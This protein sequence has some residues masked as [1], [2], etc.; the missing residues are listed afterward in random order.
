MKKRTL[1][2]ALLP[3]LAVHALATITLQPAQPLPGQ[4]IELKFQSTG[5][6]STQVVSWN[7]GDGTLLTTSNKTIRHTYKQAGTYTVKVQYKTL[8]GMIGNTL[9]DTRTVQVVERRRIIA[10]PA[11]PG[12]GQVVSLQA[13]HCFSDRL[14]WDFGDGQVTRT[15]HSCTHSYQNPGTYQIKV[16]EQSGDNPV[17]IQKTLSVVNNRSITFTPANPAPGQAVN[18]KAKKF[19]AGCVL[20]NFGDG[21]GN[22]RGQ[23][24]AAHTFST[25]GSF[26]VSARDNCGDSAPITRTLQVTENRQVVYSPQ[27]PACGQVVTFKA[28]RFNAGCVLWDFGDNSGQTR[29]QQSATHTFSSP[30]T[31]QISARDNC[32]DAPPITASIQI[33]QCRSIEVS[34]SPVRTG[35]AID[36]SA[37]NF[38]HPCVDWNFGDG[39]SPVQ[40]QALQAHIFQKPGTYRITATDDCGRPGAPGA[41]ITL[42]VLPG[43]SV[44]PSLR[45]S[46]VRIHFEN[47]KTHTRIPQGN[48][49]LQAVAELKTMGTGSLTL[50]WLVDG[51]LLNRRTV[52]VTISGQTLIHSGLTP[53]LPTQRPGRHKVTLRFLTPRQPVAVPTIEYTVRLAPAA[54]ES[55]PEVRMEPPAAEIRQGEIILD[56]PDTSQIEG[57]T[58][59]DLRP[60]SIHI[61]TGEQ[62]HSNPHVLT[63]ES[64]LSWELLGDPQAISFY[65]VEFY[66]SQ[67]EGSQRLLATRRVPGQQ[68]FLKSDFQLIHDLRDALPQGTASGTRPSPCDPTYHNTFNADVW[69]TVKGYQVVE[70]PWAPATPT[71]QPALNRTV[72]PQPF[73]AKSKLKF[74]KTADEGWPREVLV[75]ENLNT[76]QYEALNL[77]DGWT[78]IACPAAGKNPGG[79]NIS[80]LDRE[81]TITGFSIITGE[82]IEEVD[83]NNYPMERWELTG[84]IDTGYTPMAVQ[85]DIQWIGPESGMGPSRVGSVTFDNI[86]VDWGDGRVE[87]LQGTPDCTM[88]DFGKSNG[89]EGR[90]LLKGSFTLK[91]AYHL[92]RKP[93]VYTIRI[94]QLPGGWLTGVPPTSE[95]VDPENILLSELGS[96]SLVYTATATPQQSSPSMNSA[97]ISS[98]SSGL[99]SAIAQSIGDALNHGVLFYCQEVIITNRMDLC[100]SG[101]LNLVDIQVTGFPARAGA[102]LSPSHRRSSQLAKKNTQALHAPAP[103][104]QLTVQASPAATLTGPQIPTASTCD[105]LFTATAAIRYFGVGSVEVRWLVDNLEIG[106]ETFHGLSSPQRQ[107]L[108]NSADQGDCTQAIQGILT[109]ESPPLPV[110]E[111]GRRNLR[112]VAR[113]VASLSHHFSN[114]MLSRAILDFSPPASVMPW[115][116]QYLDHLPGGITLNSSPAFTISDGLTLGELVKF[117]NAHGGAAYLAMLQNPPLQVTVET[118]YRVQQARP[119]SICRLMFP[120]KKGDFLITNVAGRLRKTAQGYSGEGVLV[121]PFTS[122]SDSNKKYGIPIS[123]QNWIIDETS[124]VVRQGVIDISPAKALSRTPAVAALLSKL[125]GRIQNA[126][127]ENLMVTLNMEFKNK[128]LRLPGDSEGTEKP[129][130]WTKSGALSSDGDWKTTA[131]LPEILLS[132]SSFRLSSPAITFDFHKLEHAPGAG[133]CTADDPSWVGVDLGHATIKPYTFDIIGQTALIL[134]TDGW[135]VNDFGVCGHVE[136]PAYSMKFK[137][138]S[139]AFDSV[140]FDATGGKFSALYKNLDVHVP[141]LEAHLKGDATLN[142]LSGQYGLN[143][144]GVTSPT[145]TRNYG[146]FTLTASNLKFTTEKNIGWVIQSKT[147]FDLRSENKTITQFIV[148]RFFYGFDGYPYFSEGE[149]QYSMNLGQS[150]KLGDTSLALKQVVLTAHGS[151]VKALGISVPCE[152]FLSENPIIPAADTQL[153]YAVLIGNPNYH[154]EGP[155]VL[156]FT[157]DVAFPLGSPLISARMS[158][159][160]TPGTG[161]A[162]PPGSGPSAG[163]PE[164]APPAG[165][166]GTRYYGRVDMSMFGGPPVD[167]QLLLGY[168]GGKS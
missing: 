145:V 4:S 35:Q 91:P 54:E 151:G 12:P 157:L 49:T 2:I 44:Q 80:N 24:A 156:P 79:V 13:L 127:K 120:T 165:Y 14:M 28:Q 21:S 150:A 48:L 38:T 46:N 52:P 141:W 18:F 112:V 104:P 22:I 71:P 100:A 33:R 59:S 87:R 107:N 10:T 117:Q 96:S 114:Q 131:A 45:V 58:I 82:A 53:P 137:K 89:Q 19:T 25:P 136:S 31:F 3:F 133:R 119:G 72:P 138:G 164:A 129:P 81:K 130:A 153:D 108:Q 86:F 15:S 32:G 36:F 102:S 20:W 99:A 27:N 142:S 78:G 83:N 88:S 161:A 90:N 109:V 167:A 106:R 93:A 135:V 6:L 29:G 7:M 158:P 154:G 64:I 94:Y 8:M 60:N 143:F 61:G 101:P 57:I 110:K 67:V 77:P 128:E 74:A 41:E 5:S 42:N 98:A 105:E 26:Q 70:C 66:D 56:C 118:P 132:W 126:Q 123:I 148:P 76:E 168:Q 147:H 73:T 124:G 163:D 146:Q 47:G 9:T 111:M 155:L 134:E 125:K 115:V 50:Q 37:R 68:P 159:E 144:S 121:L 162:S 23:K 152:A 34:Q 17:T 62:N 92:Y 65:E 30:G 55:K 39:G 149:K 75:T 97:A 160:Y 69:W 85:G 84:H 40:G 113:V 139:I 166:S 1:L 103:Q 140:I 63:N 11:V 122:A 16:R 43:I 51:Q 116:N 95:G